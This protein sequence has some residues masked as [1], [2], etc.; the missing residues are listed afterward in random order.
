[1]SDCVISF[2][3]IPPYCLLTSILVHVGNRFRPNAH[4]QGGSQA[5]V[6]G[7]NGVLAFPQPGSYPYQQ[8][9]PYSPFGWV[10]TCNSIFL[11]QRLWSLLASDLCT[12]KI[13]AQLT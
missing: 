6:P 10:Q 7:Y 11:S 1:M 9:Y 8:G 12:M 5:G 13:E 2:I 4:F 3:L